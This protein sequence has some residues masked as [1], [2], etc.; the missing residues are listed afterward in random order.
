MKLILLSAFSLSLSAAYT[1]LDI[2]PG[3][4]EYTTDT[5]AIMDQTLANIPEAQREMVKKM[6][7]K[8]AG[9]MIKP[10]KVCQTK[11]MINDPQ[12]V[13]KQQMANNPKMKECKYDILK[14]SKSYAKIKFNCKDGIGAE[15]EVNVKSP[16]EQITTANTSYPTPNTVIKTVGKWISNDCSGATSN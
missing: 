14:S 12:G 5:S 9:V 16:T 8:S 13:F 3:L 6:M 1:P 7:A 10:V 15:V 11:E 2:K 4:W